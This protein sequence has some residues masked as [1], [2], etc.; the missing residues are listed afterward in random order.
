MDDELLG[1]EE[2]LCILHALCEYEIHHRTNTKPVIVWR[3]GEV[4]K[5]KAKLAEE[6]AIDTSNDVRPEW[7]G[8]HD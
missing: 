8:G 2:Q 7:R 3:M 5:L 4:G 6:W 1:R